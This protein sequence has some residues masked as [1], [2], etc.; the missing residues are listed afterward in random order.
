MTAREEG[1]TLSE[2]DT[3]EQVA[4]VNLFS[5]RNL[6]IHFRS[7]V[8][9]GIVPLGVFLAIFA[10]AVSNST[11]LPAQVEDTPLAVRAVPAFTSLEFDR[12]PETRFRRP[13]E[14]THAG[15]GS[16]RVFVAEQYGTIRVFENTPHVSTSKVF[17]DVESRV[18]YKDKE[19]EEGLLGLAFHPDYKNN[20][21][22]FLYYTTSAEPHVSVVSRFKVSGDDPDQADP[23]SEEEILRIQQP[24][25]NHN[26]GTIVFGPDGYLYIALGDGGKAN[27]V[28][29][30][31]QNLKS[32]LGGILR[33][34][35]D[36]KQGDLNYAIPADNPFVGR[37][38][39]VREEIWA[40]G[41]R[42]V[43]RMQFDSET[44]HLWAGDVGQ[45]LWEEIDII[46]RGGNY[47]WN[48]R[49]AT[50]KFQP[51]G[52]GPRDDLI[53]PIWEYVHDEINKNKSITGGFVY[54][55]KNLPKLYG[56]YLYADYVSGNIWALHYDEA[57]KKVIANYSLQ[58]PKF[59]VMSFGQ[60][61]Q[62]EPYFTT[63]FGV[64]FG[65]EEVPE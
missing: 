17:L 29:Q 50:H 62:G 1:L 64:I 2:N 51:N 16:N 54:R 46:E 57:N 18:T 5:Q 55:G 35:V 15:D 44:G 31:G 43:W 38:D 26:G 39:G 53:E 11:S 60:D 12:E 42:N 20:G 33:I 19:N 3:R 65:F 21:E 58:G 13:I 41:L 10:L 32:L 8:G 59:P 28:F 25:W 48:L 36:R 56:M 63:P 9:F 47:G 22:F 14:V 4:Y 37:G 23:S 45:N 40:Y 49:E 34:D 61:E 30:N 24:A 6:M 27:D 7:H 52:S